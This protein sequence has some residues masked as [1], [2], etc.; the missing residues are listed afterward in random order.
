MN[1][2]ISAV[3]VALCAVPI[4]ALVSDHE[5]VPISIGFAAIMITIVM[6]FGKM[7]YVN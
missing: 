3:L 2:W 4:A 5:H 7:Y 6:F 1:S